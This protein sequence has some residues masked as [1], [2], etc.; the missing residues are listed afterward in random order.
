MAKGSVPLP[1]RFR[2]ATGRPALKAA[3]IGSRTARVTAFIRAVKRSGSDGVA[4]RLFKLVFRH[5]TGRQRLGA[6]VGHKLVVVDPGKAPPDTAG[7]DLGKKA[8]GGAF[9]GHAPPIAAR[10]DARKGISA[11]GA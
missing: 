9:G 3:V 6:P 10:A 7:I 11:C 4:R 2:I 1:G 8:D 5:R